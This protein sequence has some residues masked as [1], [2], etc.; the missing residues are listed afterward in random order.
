MM[1]FKGNRWGIADFSSCFL[2]VPGPFR[3]SSKWLC[4]GLRHCRRTWYAWFGVTWAYHI[5]RLG[6]TQRLLTQKSEST[7]ICAP[8]CKP[9]FQQISWITYAC[10]NDMRLGETGDISL[11]LW[12][13]NRPGSN[14]RHGQLP[15][16]PIQTAVSHKSYG[17]AHSCWWAL[18]ISCS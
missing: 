2:A 18:G 5:L 7:S 12:P 16:N 3:D 8:I 15:L 13:P 10:S 17:V 9:Q 4:S 14:I 11:Y 1:C 6:S